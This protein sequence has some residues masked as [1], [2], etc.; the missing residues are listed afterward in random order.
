MRAGE[1]P[2]QPQNSK[3]NHTN[4]NYLFPQSSLVINNSRVNSG[5]SAMEFD[6]KSSRADPTRNAKIPH[7]ASAHLAPGKVDMFNPNA[8]GVGPDDSP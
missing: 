8:G 5:V 1:N 3:P 2:D 4:D 6:N 7:D